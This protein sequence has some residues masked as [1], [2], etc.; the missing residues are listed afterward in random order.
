MDFKQYY[1]ELI[2]DVNN[3]ITTRY[4]AKQGDTKSRGFYV[5]LTQNGVVIPVTTETMTF[6]AKKP[7]NTSVYTEAIKDGTI[8]RL[9]LHNQVFAVKGVVLCELTL[10]GIADEIISCRTFEIFVDENLAN[11]NLIS[12]DERGMIEQ[13]LL[14]MALINGTE[15][16]RV[17]NESTRISSETARGTTEG[18]RVTAE[19]GRVSAES[20]RVTQNN[21]RT[22]AET[23][24]VT[25]ESTRVTA[26]ANRTTN[27]TTRMNAETTRGTSEGTRVSNESARATAETARQLLITNTYHRGTY[28]GVTAYLKNNVVNYNGSSYMAKQNTTGNLPTNTTYWGLTASKGVDGTGTAVATTT[29]DGWMAA[30]DKVELNLHTAQ[31]AENMILNVNDLS[32]NKQ[33]KAGI[34]ISAEG[35]PQFIYEEV[36]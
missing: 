19:T 35:K 23:G 11:D 27:E 24:R 33:Y 18:L 31:L 34:Q 2:F 7:D 12:A 5:T 14:D 6:Y 16:T 20:T 17:S 36:L 15:A 22:I 3:R 4:T 1:N 8:F 25:A 26:D 28:A 29:T 30:A 13:A 9:D 21:T 10:K 32:T